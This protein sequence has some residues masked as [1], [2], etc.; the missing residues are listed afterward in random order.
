MLDLTETKLKG[1]GEV[2]WCGLNGITT[3]VHEIERAREGLAV[4]MN[5]EWRNAMIGVRYVSSRIVWVKFKFSRIKVCIVAVYGLK[6]GKVK[7]RLR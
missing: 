4:L 3:C 1:N 6:E 2:S 5:D 7:E